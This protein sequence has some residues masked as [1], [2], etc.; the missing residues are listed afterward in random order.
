MTAATPEFERFMGRVATDRALWTDFEALCGF[1]GRLA[2]SPGE[3]AAR[4]WAA[5]R[6]AAVP[7]GVLRRDPVRY[8]GWTCHEARLQDL[9]T[10]HDLAVT[11]LL[12]SASTPPE[13]I[14][15]EVVDCAR[16]A[17]EQIASAGVRGKAALVRHE[18]PFASWTI[19]RRVKLAAAIDAGAAAFLIAQPEPGIGPVS[20]SAG[21]APGR[22]IPGLGVSAEAAARITAP[23]SRVHLTLRAE[24]VPNALTETIVLYLPGR[25][26][27]QVVLSAHID[28]HSLAESALDNATGVAAALSLARSV[29]PF[30]AGMERGLTVCIFSAEEWALTGSRVWLE[31]LPWAERARIVFNLNLDSI[32]GSPSLTALTSGFAALGPIMHRAAAQAGLTLHVHEPLMTNSDHANFAAHGIPAIRLLAGF[33]DPGSNLRYLLTGADTVLLANTRELKASALTAGAV[34]WAALQ[35]V[36]VA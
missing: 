10:G 1:G 15:L 12:A 8:T 18:Y 13:G 19:H 4:D 35:A 20:G 11:P 27:E 26:P 3:R 5:A 25:G 6:L 31:Q 22:M 28:G 2:G 29:A 9:R 24:E 34:L 7:G 16:G 33:G 32:A 36:S 17:P 30:V 14:L 21:L 23:G